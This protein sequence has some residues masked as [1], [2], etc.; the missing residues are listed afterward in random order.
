MIPMKRLPFVLSLL[1]AI[2]LTARSQTFDCAHHPSDSA[3]YKV[4]LLP[5][6]ITLSDPSAPQES[7]S[8]VVNN[9][10]I[11]R[12]SSGRNEYVLCPDSIKFHGPCSMVDTMSASKLF[13][14]LGRATAAMAV[15]AGYSPCSSVCVM[16]DTVRV[17][18]PSCVHRN[19]SG[20]STSFTLCGPG[21]AANRDYGVCCPVGG[22]T[23]N[24]TLLSSHGNGCNGSPGGCESVVP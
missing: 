4:G 10:I 7:F 12:V 19:G 6:T 24:V 15:A 18:Q 14:L 2:V 8:S 16:P 23:P 20:G 5:V 21:V 9:V 11:F 13:D 17:Y 22:P 3:A 1:L